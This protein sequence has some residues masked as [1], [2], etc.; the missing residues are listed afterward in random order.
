MIAWNVFLDN[1]WI[2][3]V[4]YTRDCDA[5]YVRTSLVN[6][7]GYNPRIKVAKRT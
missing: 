6:H 7:D 4:F 2:D 5:Q 1:K 3:T